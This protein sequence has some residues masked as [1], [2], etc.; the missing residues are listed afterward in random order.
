MKLL[1]PPPGEV[2]TGIVVTE[3][4]RLKRLVKTE[5]FVSAKNAMIAIIASERK[6]ATMP[7]VC[8]F[9]GEGDGSILAM[10]SILYS[11]KCR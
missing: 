4:P 3:F 9:R 5:T 7:P 1:P 10:F 8:D 6:I 11:R 2:T